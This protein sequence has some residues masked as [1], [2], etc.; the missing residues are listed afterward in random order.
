MGEVIGREQAYHWSI[1]R[2]AEA[3]GRDRRTVATLIKDAGIPPAGTRRGNPVYRLGDV[4]DAIS[5]DRRPAASGIDINDLMPQDRKAWYQSENERV[6]LERELRH[7]VP[8]DDVQ[9]EMAALAKAMAS[10]LDSLADMLE[11]DAGLPPEAIEMVERV[12]DAI[13]EQMYRAI[14]END[15]EDAAAEA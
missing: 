11:R 3:I 1:S 5:T 10:S 7:L 6:K 8:V 15:D 4:V 14:I 12:T 9:R 13:R 2:I